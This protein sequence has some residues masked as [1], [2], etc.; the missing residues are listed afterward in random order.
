[1]KYP[2]KD[3]RADETF[4]LSRMVPKTIYLTEAFDNNL[5]DLLAMVAEKG[6]IYVWPTDLRSGNFEDG[7]NSYSYK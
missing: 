3:L 5:A 2:V 7:E 1:M 4:D 6:W